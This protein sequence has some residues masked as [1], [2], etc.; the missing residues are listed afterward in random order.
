M[1]WSQQA[2]RERKRERGRAECTA[3]NAA[4]KSSRLTSSLSSRT[5]A[6]DRLPG[7]SLTH[8]RLLHKK[9]ER[10]PCAEV[11]VRGWELIV[12]NK[13]VVA[14]VAYGTVQK[15]SPALWGHWSWSWGWNCRTLTLAENICT[16]GFNGC[17]FR[18]EKD[19]PIACQAWSTPWYSTIGYPWT[20]SWWT[21]RWNCGL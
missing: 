14:G 20:L 16:L 2:E 17:C 15:C 6:I 11:Q 9:V 12:L 5:A 7:H 3:P 4:L 1:L 18:D 21:F 13:L 10:R 19:S 8:R